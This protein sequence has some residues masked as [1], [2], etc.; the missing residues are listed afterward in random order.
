MTTCNTS[1]RTSRSTTAPSRSWSRA[2]RG[3]DL[4]VLGIDPGSRY[5]GFGVVEDAGGA[6]VRHV[7]HGGVAVAEAGRRDGRLAARHAAL[8][9]RRRTAGPDSVAAGGG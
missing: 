6:V 5:C 7:G 1:M 2:R 4:R 9:G 8:A 3:G